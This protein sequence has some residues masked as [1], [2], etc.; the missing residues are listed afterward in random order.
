M[1]CTFVLTRR[2]FKFVLVFSWKCGPEKY[3]ILIENQPSDSLDRQEDKLRS[4]NHHPLLKW[5]FFIGIDKSSTYI[6]KIKVI[7]WE[8]M[9]PWKPLTFMHSEK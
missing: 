5:R 3:S 2:W 9:V 8:S 1:Y 6:I 4:A 7:F